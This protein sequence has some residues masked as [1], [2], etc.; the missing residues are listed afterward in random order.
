MHLPG[1]VGV[2]RIIF[3]QKVHPHAKR[4]F[5]SCLVCQIQ[6]PFVPFLASSGKRQVDVECCLNIPS[7]STLT[8]SICYAFLSLTCPAQ[9]LHSFAIQCNQLWISMLT[10]FWRSGP[11]RNSIQ[12][13]GAFSVQNEFKLEPVLFI[14][15]E[16][17]SQKTVAWANSLRQPLDL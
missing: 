16:F 11:A 5:I 14:Q 3:Q 4:P 2:F 10:L 15:K 6:N 13:V 1:N 7:A 17:K 12:K 9:S 8:R